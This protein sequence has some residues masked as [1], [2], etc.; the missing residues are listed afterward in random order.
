MSYR[1]PVGQAISKI[2]RRKKEKEK[3]KETSVEKMDKLR[4]SQRPSCKIVAK[5]YFAAGRDLHCARDC[6][7]PITGLRRNGRPAAN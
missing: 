3:I 6:F 4:P 7:H 1:L 5:T 2:R